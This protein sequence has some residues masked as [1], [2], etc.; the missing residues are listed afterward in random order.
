MIGRLGLNQN[1]AYV[2]IAK[3]TGTAVAINSTYVILVKRGLWWNLGFA[4]T[5]SALGIKIHPRN[6]HN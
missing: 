4:F 1:N 5:Y 6:G 2:I 3:R